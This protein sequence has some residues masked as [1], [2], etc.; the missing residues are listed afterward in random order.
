MKFE[1]RLIYK[2]KN[3]FFYFFN[4]F[5]YFKI[6]Y[7]LIT[8]MIKFLVVKK[9]PDLDFFLWESEVALFPL[10]LLIS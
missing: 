8:K 10:S 1:R 9:S 6:I 4:F 3:I 2:F 7:N 5:N